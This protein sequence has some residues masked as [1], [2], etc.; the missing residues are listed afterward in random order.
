M[1]YYVLLWLLALLFLSP[2]SRGRISFWM[3]LMKNAFTMLPTWTPLYS[4]MRSMA[5]IPAWKTFGSWL[6]S[7]PQK[8]GALSPATSFDF[9][10]ISQWTL[11]MFK[12]HCHTLASSVSSRCFTYIL[13]SLFLKS[14][15]TLWDLWNG[16]SAN[17]TISCSHGDGHEAMSTEPHLWISCYIGLSEKRLNPIVPNGFAD[18]YPYIK[19]LFHWGY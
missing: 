2:F 16:Q 3:D 9:E 19:W 8:C 11:F 17:V 10:N 1:F 12:Q 5:W 14:W 4:S 13:E 18:H 6:D 15:Q 7:L